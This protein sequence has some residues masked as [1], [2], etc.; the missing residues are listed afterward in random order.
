HPG[1]GMRLHLIESDQRSLQTAECAFASLVFHASL[2]WF[3]LGVI[4]GAQSLSEDERLTM[5]LALL[6]PARREAPPAGQTELFR[7]GQGGGL[8]TD[9]AATD[10]AGGGDPR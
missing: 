9:W 4:A 6:P 1:R 3:A 7:L 8:L 2:V 10:A 5:P